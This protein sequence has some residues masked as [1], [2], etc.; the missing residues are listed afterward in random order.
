[1]GLETLYAVSEWRN[2]NRRWFEAQELNAEAERQ[3]GKFVRD[4]A[5]QSVIGQREPVRS[6]NPVAR[7]AESRIGTWGYTIIDPSREARGR[8]DNFL[9]TAARGI[10]DPK[11]NKFVWDMLSKGGAPAGRVDG[12]RIP[13][14]RDWGD[15]QSQI[16]GYSPITGEPQAGDVVSN[17]H[18]VGI[19]DPLPDGGRGTV[20]AASWATRPPFGKVVHNDWGFRGEEGPVTI[21]RRQSPAPPRSR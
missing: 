3:G 6:K 16:A 4:G 17:G 8:R 21:W 5:N 11:C 12:G 9:P 18:H 15:P 7:A 13:I 20:S 10:G 19:Y 2:A 1:M 14:A